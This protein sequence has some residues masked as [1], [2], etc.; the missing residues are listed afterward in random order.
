M[1]TITLEIMYI[2]ILNIA[3]ANINIERYAKNAVVV[4]ARWI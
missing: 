2:S 1:G 4:P 3:P